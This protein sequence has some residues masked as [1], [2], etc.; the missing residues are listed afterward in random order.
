M[1]YGASGA[2]SCILATIGVLQPEYSI[3]LFLLGNV[4]LKYIVLVTIVIQILSLGTLQNIGGTIDHIGGIIFGVIFAVQ[5]QKGNDLTV[6]ATKAM[7]WIGATWNRVLTPSKDHKRS[8]PRAAY[9]GGKSV[10]ETAPKSRPSFMR[11]AEGGSGKSSRSG[12]D[13]TFEDSGMSHQEQLDAI[14]DKIKDRGYNS[15]SK[16]EKDFLFRASNQQ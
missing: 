15:L 9:R 16:D 7:D 4:R 2:V 13:S 10:R 5:L 8:G 1:A 11:K 6:Y 3:R 12:G 14:L